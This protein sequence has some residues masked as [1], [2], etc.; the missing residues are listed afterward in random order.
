MECYQDKNGGVPKPPE[1][2]DEKG[3]GKGDARSRFAMKDLEYPKLELVLCKRGVVKK[4]HDENGEEKPG[5]GDEVIAY[6]DGV[7]GCQPCL[8]IR[9]DHMLK[10]EYYILYRPDF[11]PWHIVKRLNIVFYSEF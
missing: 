2:K 8:T 5:S 10:G 9:L 4:S 3:K 11:K 7:E 1:E 6:V